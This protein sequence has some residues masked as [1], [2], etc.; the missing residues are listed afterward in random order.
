MTRE[1]HLSYCKICLNRDLDIKQGLICTL[2]ESLADFKETCHSFKE[3]P[4]TKNKLDAVPSYQEVE[5]AT[6]LNNG[7]Q[8]FLWIF[9]LSAINSIILF[10]GGGVSFIFGLGIT[11]L[12]E[13]LYI[14]VIGE[15][16]L[17]GLII[18][19][20]IAGIFGVIWYFSKKL[21]QSAFIVGMGIYGLDALLLLTFKDYLSFG[22]HLYALFMIFKGYQSI[23]ELKRNV[24]IGN[25]I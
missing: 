25:K 18:S 5:S 24:T 16:N 15:L 21:N 11:Q 12:F 3:D 7:A 1:E 23:G 19:I 10:L 4:I 2:T 13:G 8:W 14:G 6:K 22:V 17:M 9:G 20:L